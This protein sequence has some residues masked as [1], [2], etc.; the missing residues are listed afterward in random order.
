M[1]NLNHHLIIINKYF[2]MTQ[3]ADSREVF[4]SRVRALSRIQAHRR[5]ARAGARLPGGKVKKSAAGKALKD[6]REGDAADVD[7]S[8]NQ[9]INFLNLMSLIIQ[10]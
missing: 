6:V 7:K 5:I 3:A 10:S 9:K 8:R 1:I 4:R 2:I